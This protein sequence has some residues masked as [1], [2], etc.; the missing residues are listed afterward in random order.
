[1][2]LAAGLF[3][4]LAALTILSILAVPLGDEILFLGGNAQQKI[5]YGAGTEPVV[6]VSFQLPEQFN[7]AFSGFKATGWNTH[8]DGQTLTIDGGSLAPGNSLIIDYKIVKY[9]PP[10]STSLSAT[11][12]TAGGQTCEG[13]GM[14]TVSQ[15]MWIV[16]FL[17]ELSQ[18]AIPLALALIPAGL[19][20]KKSFI[21]THLQTSQ[22][23]P[24][25]PPPPSLE[26][27]GTDTSEEID[28][29]P[30]TQTP[31]NQPTKPP[32]KEMRVFGVDIT[33]CPPKWLPEGIGYVKFK[34]KIYECIE[35]KWVNGPPDFIT[36]HLHDV[37]HE[38]G[39]CMNCGHSTTPDLWFPQQ[40]GF[41]VFGENDKTEKPCEEKILGKDNPH[42]KH[43][44]SAK[45]EKKVPDAEVTVR[46]EDFG[47]WGWIEAMAGETEE[48]SAKYIQ[49]PPRENAASPVACEGTCCGV[50]RKNILIS[51]GS[52]PAHWV[53]IP[54]DED[55]NNIADDAPQNKCGGEEAGA[56]KDDDDEPAGEFTGDG[57]TAYEEYRGFIVN[58]G[59]PGDKKTQT[60]IRTSIKKRDVFIYVENKEL[61]EAVRNGYFK[62]TGLGVHIIQ[63]ENL[64]GGKFTREINFNRGYGNP[65]VDTCIQ[66]AIWLKIG[67]LKKGF[68]SCCPIKPPPKWDPETYQGVPGTP[69]TKTHVCINYSK[70]V[71][72]KRLNQIV[73]HELGHAINLYHHGEGGYHIHSDRIKG[74]DYQY[75]DQG[76]MTSGDPECVMRL[77]TADGWCTNLTGQ[78]V[79]HRKYTAVGG[80]RLDHAGSIFC[81]T[82]KGTGINQDDTV[83]NDATVGNC[84]SHIKVKDW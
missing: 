71:L 31:E 39:I 11:F 28:D 21:T 70:C 58:E 38:K 24:P 10:G 74:I 77:D 66:H 61:V 27:E 22:P 23:P 36:F 6:S 52:K 75:Y 73:A 25:P 80:K 34:A 40:K 81:E 44:L 2:K 19:Y 35:G 45:T 59:A 12:T 50:L 72:N 83:T 47:A 63:D 57:L 30:A 53:K 5:V 7:G 65:N 62:K 4:L 41:N 60:H 15:I 69:G 43:C 51:A 17:Q 3:S 14:I 33:K 49:I 78:H 84:K 32:N 8:I 42:H 13:T 56:L 16:W 82:Q 68:G 9:V 20:W 29:T 55:G 1:L 64:V 37:S 48:E 18:F 76:T 79:Q 54:R 46:S 67:D 26:E